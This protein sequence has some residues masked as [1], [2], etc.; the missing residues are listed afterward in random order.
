MKNVHACATDFFFFPSRLRIATEYT[1][2][3][4]DINVYIDAVYRLHI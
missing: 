1:A 2:N 3:P 4:A